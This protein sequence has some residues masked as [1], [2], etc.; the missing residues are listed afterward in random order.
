M[1]PFKYNPPTRT[2]CQVCEELH[3]NDVFNPILETH[4][5]KASSA[6]N[7][8]FHNWYNFVLGYSPQFPEYM[9]RREGITNTDLVVDPFMGSGTTL[10]ACKQLGLHSIGIDAND[11][12]VDTARIKLDWNLDVKAL[13]QCR[14]DLLQQIENLYAAY[15][16]ETELEFAGQLSLFSTLGK[17]R[18]N[19]RPILEDQRPEMLSERYIS[20]KPLAR[21]MLIDRIIN[22]RFAESPFKPLFD[23]ALT[24]LI[25]PI[26][27]VRYGPGFGVIKPRED[28]DV[29]G[30]YASKLNR[31]V[32]DLAAVSDVQ[33]RTSSDVLLGDSRNLS[34]YIEPN[35]ASLMIT[36]P[37][38]P[39]DHEYTK[40]TRL[41]LIFRGY[42]SNNEEFQTIKRRMLR[43]STTNIYKED[44][45]KQPIIGLK[46]IQKITNL[47]QERLEHDGATSGFEKLY[48]KL[49]WEYFGGM[50]KALKESY[51]V[52]QSGGKIALL[53][54]DSHAFKMV[55]IQTAAIL[56]EIGIMVGFVEPEIVPWQLK[57]STSHK[58]WL[59]ENILILKK[60]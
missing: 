7:Y 9:L 32:E 40:H 24:A 39:G 1:M 43:A 36:S 50:Y 31:M 60:P 47:I 34:S 59:R 44:N 10:V 14:D 57:P 13:R 11:F 45:D 33:K 52:L 4:D 26:S 8:P 17:V 28:A 30:V 6:N 25:V 19:Y 53:V 49:V 48:T 3:I 21:A 27:N 23:L 18:R 16:W 42:A 37:P 54:S 29:M 56:Q 35:T 58:Y 12:M 46:S 41:E 20:D 22:A 15:D 38:Y 2:F 51:H 5:G 55:H